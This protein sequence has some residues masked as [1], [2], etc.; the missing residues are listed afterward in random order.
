MNSSKKELTFSDKKKLSRLESCEDNIKSNQAAF[1]SCCNSV[2]EIIRDELW[3][4]SE[5]ATKEEYFQNKWGWGMKRAYQLAKASEITEALPKKLSTNVENEGQARAIAKVPS[6]RREE[7]L[8]KAKESGGVTASSIEAA[9]KSIKQGKVIQL[10]K[11]GRPIPD[12]VLPDWE[13]AEETATHLRS[14]ISEVKCAVAKG[15]KDQD[16]IF[17]ELHNPDIA[18][19]EANHYT[20][21]QILPFSICT[22]CSGQEGKKKCRLCNGRGFISKFRFDQCVPAETKALLIRKK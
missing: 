3:K 10:D 16:I 2:A 21:S 12:A 9:S 20:L 6:E 8:E 19:L 18:S 7:V 13:R 22:T 15:L 4:L 1:L 14:L 5:H 17:R 11:N